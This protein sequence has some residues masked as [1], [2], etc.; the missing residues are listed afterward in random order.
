M[1]IDP[2]RIIRDVL[3]ALALTAIA[4]LLV[5]RFVAVPWVVRGESME[6]T[7]KAGDRVMVDLWTYQW[8]GPRQGEVALLLG[9]G[10]VALVKRVVPLP[11][12]R[13]PDPL[14][15]PASEEPVH[16]VLG[17][18]TVASV[19]SRT[20]GAVPERRFLGRVVWRYRPLSRAGRIP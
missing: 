1:R 10:D 13:L 7:L 19:D 12:G 6:P 18:N 20:F 2:R 8:R 11:A 4:V 15:L 3:L 5:T 16:F 17:D 14:L 9:P